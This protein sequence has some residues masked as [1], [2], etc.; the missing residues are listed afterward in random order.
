[1]IK[2]WLPT[3]LPPGVVV[4]RAAGGGQQ[5]QWCGR[6]VRFRP[7]PVLVP[8]VSQAR[9]QRTRMV[10]FEY[11]QGVLVRLQMAAAS[12]GAGD[13]AEP[14][15]D[16]CGDPGAVGYDL[17]AMA[18]DAG[19]LAG[20]AARPDEVTPVQVRGRAPAPETSD[21][22]AGVTDRGVRYTMEILDGPEAGRMV[23]VTELRGGLMDQLRAVT[24][25]LSTTPVDSADPA[26]YERLRAGP[27]VHELALMSAA[28]RV[29]LFKDGARTPFGRSVWAQRMSCLGARLAFDLGT[30][31][32]VALYLPPAGEIGSVGQHGA[33]FVRL[34]K[35]PTEDM[36][37]RETLP[38]VVTATWE[39]EIKARVE[40]PGARILRFRENLLRAAEIIRKHGA[41][42]VDVVWEEVRAHKGVTAAHVYGELRGELMAF[43]EMQRWPY[44]SL[45]VQWGK[46]AITG[47]GAASKDAVALGVRRH[48][49][50]LDPKSLDA[51]D[52]LS[53]LTA[54]LD[55]FGLM[56]QP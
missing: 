17:A 44:R 36:M 45:P 34:L 50:G 53:A 55:R 25:G 29:R 47:S 22:E 19:G 3:P 30:S 27:C 9:L 5:P 24:A 54:C 37:V 48:W 8:G 13:L 10:P 42:V 26:Y 15:D 40:G 31:C 16:A 18:L 51:S 20:W 39:L 14:T 1:M 21:T 6:A 33:S 52:A 56:S 46:V 4:V 28:D 32:G 49:I 41:P 23:S 2:H 11:S 38:R 12:A 7:V 43:C 35:L